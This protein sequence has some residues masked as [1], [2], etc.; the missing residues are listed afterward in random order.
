VFP[1][2][3]DFG[4]LPLEAMACGRPVLAYAGGVA[5]HTVKPGTTG[6]LFEDQSAEAIARAVKDFDPEAYQPDRIRA[7]AMQWDGSVFRERLVRAV[8]SVAG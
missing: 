6:E 1:S 8:E 7:H 4:L 2:R 3:D 5:R